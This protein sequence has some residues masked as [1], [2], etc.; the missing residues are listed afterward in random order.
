MR[1]TPITMF[2]DWFVNESNARKTLT[3]KNIQEIN[4]KLEQLLSVEKE[5]LEEF[6]RD[7][8]GY[9]RYKGK[10]DNVSTEYIYDKVFK[11]E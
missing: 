11:I 6:H 8:I 2:M 3:D 9:Q 7:G 4:N 5:L 10:W 1:K